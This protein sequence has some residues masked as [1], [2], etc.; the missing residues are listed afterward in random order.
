MRRLEGLEQAE[1]DRATQGY[2]VLGS[3]EVIDDAI[4]LVGPYKETR[5]YLPM[6]TPGIVSEFARVR[7]G[8]AKSALRFVNRWGLLGHGA[9]ARDGS[10]DPLDWI[11]AHANGVRV[12]LTIRKH[13]GDDDRLHDYLSDLGESPFGYGIGLHIEPA[14]ELASLVRPG[15]EIIGGAENV[16][17][18]HIINP[19]LRGVYFQLMD[20]APSKA[21]AEIGRYHLVIK[22]DALISVIYRHLADIVTG[23]RVRLCDSCGLPFRV[24]QGR[25]RFCPGSPDPRTGRNQRSLCEGRYTKARR[26]R[27][28]K[29]S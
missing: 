14:S 17:L 9:L 24:T 20:G 6:G 29:K 12:A 26:R 7:P 28:G 10:G 13:I 11:F 25:Q 23:H 19:N 18:R 8:N 27:E 22:W 15:G 16:Y 21:L 5:S 2:A 1:L 3:Y 4:Q